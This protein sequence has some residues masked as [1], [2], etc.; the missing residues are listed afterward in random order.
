MDTVELF[1]V[2]RFHYYYLTIIAI[3]GTLLV[4]VHS[5]VLAQYVIVFLLW[6]L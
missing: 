5:A 1:L 3:R 2:N 6:I 4:S